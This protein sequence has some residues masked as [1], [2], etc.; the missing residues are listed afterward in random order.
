[1]FNPERDSLTF[2]IPN[3]SKRVIFKKLNRFTDTMNLYRFLA[4]LL[5]AKSLTFDIIRDMILC[6]I[7]T[8][9][10]LR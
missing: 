7:L 3:N 5:L 6:L 1:M 4:L 9:S 2:W 8:A 10:Q